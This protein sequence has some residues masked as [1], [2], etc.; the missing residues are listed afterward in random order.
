MLRGQELSMALDEIEAIE[1]AYTRISQEVPPRFSISTVSSS[2]S[3]R[4]VDDWKFL[5]DPDLKPQ[6][7]ALDKILKDTWNNARPNPPIELATCT[8]P[9]A[10]LLSLD[11]GGIKGVSSLRILDAIMKKVWKIENPQSDYPGEGMK[12]HQY[13]QLAAG[14]STGGLAAVMLFRLR[15]YVPETIQA[16]KDFAEAIFEPKIFGWSFKKL[17]GFGLALGNFW[18]KVKMVFNQARYDPAALEAKTKKIV[19]DHP[20]GSNGAEVKLLDPRRLPEEGKM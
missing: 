4:N 15:M 6:L 11:G 16:Y 18:L 2:G 14:T 17:G 13:F 5:S 19:A 7:E 10:R 20:P 3:Q 9:G 1:A 8:S 12:V